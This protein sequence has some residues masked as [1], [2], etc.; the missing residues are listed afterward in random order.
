[1]ESKE[2]MKIAILAL[3]T[4]VSVSFGQIPATLSVVGVTQND[5]TLQLTAG[6]QPIVGGFD[7]IYQF[8]SGIDHLV[9]FSDAGNIRRGRTWKHL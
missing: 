1:M 8:S 6:S 3:I 7:I 9:S 5:V 2:P 4:L